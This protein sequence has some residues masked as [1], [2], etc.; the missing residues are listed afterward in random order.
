MEGE[1]RLRIQPVDATLLAAMQLQVCC[2][3]GLNP[4]SIAAIEDSRKRTSA[5]LLC[6]CQPRAARPYWPF[7]RAHGLPGSLGGVWD[8]AP[9]SIFRAVLAISQTL[10]ESCL[11]FGNRVPAPLR[12]HE[13]KGAHVPCAPLEL[14]ERS[15]REVFLDHMARHVPPAQASPEQVVLR[16]EVI[17]PPLA[18]AG[19]SLLGLFRIGLIVG[20][21]ELDVSAE[22]LPRNRLRHCGQRMR[23]PTYGHHLCIT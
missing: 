15:L 7:L 8:R 2:I 12:D 17:H 10:K 1:C 22:F 3:D 19:D 6:R 20:D 16:A 5:C 4:Q 14:D 18:F 21:D 11:A 13:R 23:W 9:G